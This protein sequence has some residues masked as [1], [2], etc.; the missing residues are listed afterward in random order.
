MNSPSPKQ[1]FLWGAATSSHQVEG[2][3]QLNDWWDWEKR[4]QPE[5]KQSGLACD[6]WQRWEEDVVLIKE[7]GHNAHRLSL[8]WSRIE[9]TEGVFDETALDHYKLI[10]QTLHK[11]GIKTV[12]TLHHFTNPQWLMV[13]GGWVNSCVVK[14]FSRYVEKVIQVLGNEM[15]FVLTINEPGV[16]AFM[17]YQ[18]GAWPPQE[19]SIWRMARVFW[20]MSRAHRAAYDIIKHRLPS[21]PVSIAHNVST[22]EAVHP[23]SLRERFA[24]RCY[25]WFNNQLFYSLSGLRTHDVL[26]VNYYFHRRLDAKGRL[27]PRFQDPKET[28]RAVSDLGWELFP[29]GLGRAVDLLRGYRKPILVTEHGLADAVDSRR[30]EFIRESLG[31]L[32]KRREEGAPVIG[33]LHWSLMDNFE[34]ADG[35]EPRFGLVEVDYVTQKRTPRPSAWVYKDII[36]KYS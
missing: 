27:W 28:G 13:N 1:D 19:R 14:R 34:W 18:V 30:P 21:L 25:N 2:N 8:E 36:E 3:N 35:F 9:P 7:L 10:L 20:N 23:K 29:E 6:Q 15:D 22:F 24:A 31:V 16:Y 12:V 11:H 33:Y 17:S 32:L 4:N 5:T 26:G